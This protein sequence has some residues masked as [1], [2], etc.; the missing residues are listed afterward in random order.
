MLLQESIFGKA[1]GRLFWF[2]FDSFSYSL[3]HRDGEDFWDS[4]N[5]VSLSWDLAQYVNY[6]GHRRHPCLK[7]GLP[8][9]AANDYLEEFDHILRDRIVQLTKLN[10]IHYPP[11]GV[12]LR[13][14]SALT[15]V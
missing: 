4:E 5:P 6:R 2:H 7:K 3:F 14:R 15:V 1:R 8:D 10:V 13:P 12:F 9:S 11:P